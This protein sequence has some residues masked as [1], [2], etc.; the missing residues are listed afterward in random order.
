MFYKSSEFLTPENLI[1]SRKKYQSNLT[2]KSGLNLFESSVHSQNG[3]DGVLEKIF[4]EIGF[5]NK[6][7][8]EFGCL[9]NFQYSN[10]RY[11][12]KKYG[13]RSVSFD[14]VNQNHKEGLFK[15]F[16]TV[17]NI[18]GIFGKYNIPIDLDLLSIDIDGNDF[19][20]W[21]ALQSNPRVV[22]IENNPLITCEF[23]R[24]VKYNPHFQY[25][26]SYFG[27]SILSIFR[28]GRSKGYSLVAQVEYNSIFIK[29]DELEKLEAE[30]PNLNDVEKFYQP[31]EGF[32][33]AQDTDGLWEESGL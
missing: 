15:E 6:T 4:G 20:A 13:L 10:T 26:N 32:W 1:K 17:E 30:I 28:L 16:I 29:D 21:K 18:N 23:D 19:W 2:S 27:A 7:C 11:L 33:I 5:S 14:S 24:I 12:S 25:K 31:Q 3:E 9:S 8:V 22:I